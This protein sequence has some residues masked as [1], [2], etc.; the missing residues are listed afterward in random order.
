M[1]KACLVARDKDLE[2][3]ALLYEILFNATQCLLSR[4][5]NLERQ[6]EKKDIFSDIT[7]IKCEET[8]ILPSR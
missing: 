7:L 2:T 1:S 5:S 3:I 4:Q 8:I 6:S